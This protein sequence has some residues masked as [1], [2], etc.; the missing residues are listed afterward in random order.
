MR[1]MTKEELEQIRS[2]MRGLGYQSY[3][4]FGESTSNEV[5]FDFE[6]NV[7]RLIKIL[8]MTCARSP[9]LCYLLLGALRLGVGAQGMRAM[10]VRGES[11]EEVH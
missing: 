10:M 6:G 9:D 3:F 2:T 8:G 1:Q 7:E 4:L 11:G 5:S